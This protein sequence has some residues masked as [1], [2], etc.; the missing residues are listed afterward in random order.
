MR[1][2]KRNKYVQIKY[3]TIENGEIAAAKKSSDN[4]Q[5]NDKVMSLIWKIMKYTQGG[6]KQKVYMKLLMPVFVSAETLIQSE[7][8]VLES[9]DQAEALKKGKLIEIAIRLSLPAEYQGPTAIDPPNPT[10][11]DISF[12]ILDELKYYVRYSHC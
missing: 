10:E 7:S 3:R 5:G 8:L 12:E 4:K 11:P 6:N 2:Y 1:L 9:N